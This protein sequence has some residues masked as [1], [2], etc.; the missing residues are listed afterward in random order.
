MDYADGY[1]EIS[2]QVKGAKQQQLADIKNFKIIVLND[3]NMFFDDVIIPGDESGVHVSMPEIEEDNVK[4]LDVCILALDAGNNVM[5]RECVLVHQEDDGSFTTVHEDKPSSHYQKQDEGK[6]DHKKIA[7]I[8]V[9]IVLVILIIIV[10]VAVYLVVARGCLSKAS[11]TIQSGIANIM[12]DK[13]MDDVVGVTTNQTSPEQP[14]SITIS[15][16]P[17]ESDTYECVS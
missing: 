11:D 16:L 15:G 5:V 1:L 8:V 17:Q 2:W 12:Y 7:V 14:T 10:A 4:E 6:R 9:P 3:E 13:Q